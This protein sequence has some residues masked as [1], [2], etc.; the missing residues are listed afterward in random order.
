MAIILS[1]RAFQS[2]VVDGKKEYW[3]ALILDK[4]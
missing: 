2:F 4:L 3:K 1:E